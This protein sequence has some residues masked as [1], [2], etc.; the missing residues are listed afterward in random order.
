MLNNFETKTLQLERT[1]AAKAISAR[2]R[3]IARDATQYAD[4]ID[5]DE[6]KASYI[7]ASNWGQE[8]AIL[9]E[10]CGVYRLLNDMVKR[11]QYIGW[12]KE[13][14]ARTVREGER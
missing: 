10:E 12:I 11:S 7:I 4:Y 2:L 13:G 14:E 3:M 5:G 8:A 9:G 6:D 1:Q